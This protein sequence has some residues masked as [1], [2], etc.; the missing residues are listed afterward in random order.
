MTSD[1]FCFSGPTGDRRVGKADC[2]RVEG[3]RGVI[4]AMECGGGTL[5]VKS[6]CS[7]SPL[8]P[9]TKAG[10]KVLSVYSEKKIPRYLLV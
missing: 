5:N 8:D 10:A 4:V 9:S 3:V 7:G 1:A 2:G 6:Y